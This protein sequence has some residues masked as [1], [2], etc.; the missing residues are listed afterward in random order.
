MK[1]IVI[2]S[3]FLLCAAA[4]FG[5][6]NIGA[7]YYYLGELDKARRNLENQ[8]SSNP[9]EANFYLGQVAF[10]E[11]DA[12][13]AAQYYEKSLAADPEFFKAQVG[14]AKLQLKTNPTAAEETFKALAK[15]YKKSAPL[16]VAVGR[17]YLDS[18]MKD[19]AAAKVTEAKKYDKKFPW[20]YILEGDIEV[21]GDNPDLGA[22]AGK[23]EQARYFDP[24]FLLAYMKLALVYEKRN[25]S[26]ALDILRSA[27][28][29]DPNYYILYSLLGKIYT[30]NGFYPEAI[31]A[32]RTY[33][34]NAEYSVNDL[35]RMARAFY[36]GDPQK[37][38][39]SEAEKY[40]E[41]L[42]FVQEG[43]ARDPNHFVLN[44]YKMYLSAKTGNYAEGLAE[45]EKFFALR[46][47]ENG[48]AGHIALDYL[49]YGSILKDAGRLGDA[50]E[51][52]NKAIAL[53]PNK[54]ETYDEAINMARDMRDYA[55]AA[56]YY[57]RQVDKKKELDEDKY[58]TDRLVDL[59]SLG[60]LYYQ[61]GTLMNMSRTP[62]LITA[63]MTDQNRID[64]ILGA[65]VGARADSLRLDAGYFANYYA[66]YNLRQADAMFRELIEAAPESY[67]GYYY[68]ARTQNALFPGQAGIDSGL[69]KQYYEKTAEL[70]EGRENDSEMSAMM[71]RALKESLAYLAYY[72]YM[73]DNKER[74]TFFS[75][76]LLELDPENANARAILDD[77]RASGK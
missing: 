14:L 16:A 30:T 44:R 31:E 17:A 5:Q 64:R 29:I 76:R 35:E 4:L 18:G 72:Y 33:F 53:E 22:A 58:Y 27:R 15:K 45:A 47:G 68:M 36:F 11:G 56:E 8:V 7:D 1:R 23:Y 54:L 48:N 42:R 25:P 43:L 20:I 38:G 32:L 24:N 63:I 40:A 70:I 57:S 55:L 3:A 75:T 41:A 10:A 51:Q 69:P 19:K 65:N 52:Y 61:A 67:T 26:M 9:A 50:V 49:M 28:E 77:L 62:A 34:A 12:A 46:T 66:K 74:A 21:S 71:S 39:L 73:T 37:L 6:T 2:T 60:N 59:N 13:R